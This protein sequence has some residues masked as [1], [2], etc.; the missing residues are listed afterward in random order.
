MP[1]AIDM[2]GEKYGYLVV[3]ER[4]NRTENRPWWKCLCQCGKTVTLRAHDLRTGNT[5]SC[6]CLR[7]ES[8]RIRA[9]KHGL[10]KSA[11]YRTWCHVIDRCTNPKCGDFHYYGGRGISIC[12]RWRQS[13]TNFY[14]D[15]GQ[16]PSPKHSIDRIDND[17]H[18]EPTN[19]RW[20]TMVQQASN[21]RPMGSA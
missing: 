17:G 20:A 15:M 1:R 4:A 3:I 12:Q 11:E 6:G 8:A 2:R 18:Y 9:T 10:R 14:A 7:S 13:F 5:K 19:C 21:R 16:R